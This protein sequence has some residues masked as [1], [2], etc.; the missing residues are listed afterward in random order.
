MTTRDSQ[1]S[2]SVSRGDLQAVIQEAERLLKDISPGEWCISDFDGGII[3]LQEGNAYPERI[4]EVEH[5]RNDDFIAAAPRLVRQLLSALLSA[6]PAQKDPPL[7]HETK[8]LNPWQ[9]ERDPLRLA[10]LGKLNEE[11]NEAGAMVAR[12]IIQGIDECEPV[13]KKGNREALTNEIADVYATATMAVELFGLSSVD[14]ARR[15]E[16]KIQHLRAWHAL[17]RSA[18]PSTAQGEPEL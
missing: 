13:T 18:S 8:A 11:L 7:L 9:P 2:C 10:V 3:A 4:A 16:R 5:H 14:I 17:I 15:M 1:S 12:C 6:P